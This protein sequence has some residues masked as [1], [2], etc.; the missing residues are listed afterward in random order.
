MTLVIT[1]LAPE[2]SPGLEKARVVR[3]RWRGVG[4][5]RV[6]SRRWGGVNRMGRGGGKRVGVV[7]VVG[8]ERRGWGG[9]G[10][11]KRVGVVV[12]VGAERRG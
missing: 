7:V 12:V 4:M 2:F 6:V 9:G 1:I 3:R 11:G 5:G 8:A 10:G